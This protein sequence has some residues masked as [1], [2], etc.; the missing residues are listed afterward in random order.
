MTETKWNFIE[1]DKF[2]EWYEMKAK[3]MEI[4]KSKVYPFLDSIIL[5]SS[6]LGCE[7]PP[8]SALIIE[9]T[10]YETQLIVSEWFDEHPEISTYTWPA[11]TVQ[12]TCS[13]VVDGKEVSFYFGEKDIE[14]INKQNQ[15]LI[16]E[17][18]GMTDKPA[19][20]HLLSLVKDKFVMS[21]LGVEIN[22]DKVGF[23]LAIS[24]PDSHFGYEA[25]SESDISAFDC[26]LRLD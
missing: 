12:H 3:N 8:Q 26:V 15:V 7:K 23:I 18:F 14:N 19:R 17:M 2:D 10:K 22:M 6:E 11:N 20:K 5:K 4:V 21:P 13:H 25:L 1:N 16:I 24:Y 9:P